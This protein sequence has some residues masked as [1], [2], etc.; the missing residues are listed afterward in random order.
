MPGAAQ[1][2]RKDQRSNVMLRASVA[3]AQGTREASISDVSERGLLGNMENP[4][5]RGEFI[6]ILLPSQEVAGQV[7]WVRG[8][9]FGVR[10]R[11]RLDVHSLFGS[12]RKPRRKSA[13]VAAPSAEGENQNALTA[14]AVLG[15]CALAAAYLIANFFIL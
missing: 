13:P 1:T 4:P 6:T 9:E 3:D 12:A 8:R 14:Y 11:E 15:I 5:E 10:L 7:R 2:D